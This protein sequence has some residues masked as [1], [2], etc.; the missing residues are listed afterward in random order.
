MNCKGLF[1]DSSFPILRANLYPFKLEAS[2]VLLHENAWYFWNWN[3]RFLFNNLYFARLILIFRFLGG[4]LYP[5]TS[6]ASPTLYEMAWYFWRVGPPI[7]TFLITIFAKL[8][9]IFQF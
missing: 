8:I 6:E 3:S 2:P 9:L 7:L 5:F 4:N 1:A